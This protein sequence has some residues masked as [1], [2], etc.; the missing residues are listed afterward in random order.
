MARIVITTWENEH[1]LYDFDVNYNGSPWS[2]GDNYTSEAAAI[3]DATLSAQ[4]RWSLR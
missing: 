1:G 2:T 4:E 3:D